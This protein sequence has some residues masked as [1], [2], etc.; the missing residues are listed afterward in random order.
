[1]LVT[2]M[3]LTVIPV[4]SERPQHA[5]VMV[6]GSQTAR[7][8]G[9]D[10]DITWRTVRFWTWDRLTETIVQQ[11]YHEMDAGLRDLLIRLG[12]VPDPA[13]ATCDTTVPAEHAGAAMSY[14][15]P[16]HDR[17]SVVSAVSAAPVDARLA[18]C[19]L[20]LLLPACEHYLPLS[21]SAARGLR[22]VPSMCSS[23]QLFVVQPMLGLQAVF[24]PFAVDAERM[25]LLSLALPQAGAGA[26]ESAL[27]QEL[28]LDE[29]GRH[30][31]RDRS[32][33]LHPGAVQHLLQPSALVSSLPAKRLTVEV[34]GQCLLYLYVLRSGQEAQLAAAHF[35]HRADTVRR[36]RLQCYALLEPLFLKYQHK[37][38]E[39]RFE[40][41]QLRRLRAADGSLCRRLQR[42]PAAP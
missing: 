4:L 16:H 24:Q 13:E 33:R 34:S 40:T 19:K 22:G 14:T 25:L 28:R 37:G 38:Q 39:I 27:Q 17:P 9:A 1:M 10:E 41:Q 7:V 20:W 18:K 30:K 2:R 26:D 32:I 36:V 12:H 3:E 29:Q 35:L 5:K 11:E 31:T 21:A 15:A 8:R 6:L 23:C 42:E